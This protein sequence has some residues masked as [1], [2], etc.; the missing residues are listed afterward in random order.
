MNTNSDRVPFGNENGKKINDSEIDAD[1]DTVPMDEESWDW[2]RARLF[3]HAERQQDDRQA[4]HDSALAWLMIESGWDV[5]R[6]ARKLGWGRGRV[7]RFLRFG[8]F[9]L[10]RQDPEGYKAR[11]GDGTKTNDI[12]ICESATERRSRHRL[13]ARKGRRCANCG[14]PFTPKNGLGK[15]CSTRCRVALHRRQRDGR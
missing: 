10:Y 3:E 4:A 2:L 11:Y 7:Q 14:S 6:L 15:T 5:D 8:R 1:L 9:L 12:E 13:D